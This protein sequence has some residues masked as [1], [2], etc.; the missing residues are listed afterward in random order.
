MVKQLE[1]MGTSK[2]ALVSVIFLNKVRLQIPSQINN[3]AG[4]EKRRQKLQGDQNKREGTKSTFLKLFE[5]YESD[6][7]DLHSS[8]FAQ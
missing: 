6:P 2:C 8:S 1:L 5:N 3:K 7:C 4:E